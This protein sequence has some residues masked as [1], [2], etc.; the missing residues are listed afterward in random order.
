MSGRHHRPQRWAWFLER[1]GYLL[2]MARELTGFFVAGYLVVLLVTLGRLGGG[3]A[4]FAQWLQ[5]LSAPAWKVAH[6][7]ALAAAVWHSV[8]WFAAVPQAMPIHLGEK[9]LPAP[10]AAVVMGYGPWLTVTAIVVWGVL[11]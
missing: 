8:T 2:F 6:A 4:A 3:E 9:R 1:P 5:T 10:L 11:R 7:V